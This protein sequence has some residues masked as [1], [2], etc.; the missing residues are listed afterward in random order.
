MGFSQS[1]FIASED[2]GFVQLCAELLEGELGTD[3]S[4]AVGVPGI[5]NDSGRNFSSF[6]NES[7][8]NVFVYAAIY[9]QDYTSLPK[10]LSFFSGQSLHSPSCINVTIIDDAA[11]ESFTVTLSTEFSGVSFSGARSL[12]EIIDNDKSKEQL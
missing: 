7:L 9:N 8:N 2:D 4:V 10:V 1:I 6:S 3:V 11:L 12:V 5:S